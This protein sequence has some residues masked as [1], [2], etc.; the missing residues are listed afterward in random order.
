MERGLEKTA[1]RQYLRGILGSARSKDAR[2]GA[3]VVLKKVIKEPVEGIV[4]PEAAPGWFSKTVPGEK[5]PSKVWHG[6]K[7]EGTQG[8]DSLLMFLPSMAAEKALGKNKV[9]EAFWKYVHSPALKADTASGHAI[10]KVPGLKG[11][12]TVK[13]KIPWGH[14]KKNL[15]KEVERPSA[16][17]PLVKVRNIAAPI[18]VGT[19]IERGISKLREH[20]KN[21]GNESMDRDLREKVAS[22]MLRLNHEN[23][24]HT[25]RAHALRFIFK[26]AEV[27]IE[28]VPQTFEELEQ[29][30]ASLMTQDLVVLE[31]AL[32]LAGG[33][34][35]LG[36][37]DSTRDSTSAASATEKFQAAI[38][39]DET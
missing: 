30:I 38:L 26:K 5:F 10:G 36:E 17:A 3:G 23:K 37:L 28:Q 34:L 39:G 31:K 12:F 6:Y 22:T 14:P 33:Q 7:R 13:E 9:R 19:G 11:L 2:R 32:E 1:I 24:E 16:L 18:L 29:K 4:R 21:K 35:K 8:T 15:Y 25:K 27:G 20:N